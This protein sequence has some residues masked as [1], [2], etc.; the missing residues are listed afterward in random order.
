MHNVSGK[1]QKVVKCKI[2]DS[3]ATSPFSNHLHLPYYHCNNC[4]TVF[5][6]EIVDNSEEFLG[7][8]QKYYFRYE[9]VREIMFGEEIL[10]LRTFCPSGNFLDFGGGAGYLALKAQDNGYNAFLVEPNSVGREIA[11][12]NGL[13]Q[14][15][16][17][18]DNI[19]D[20]IEFDIVVINHAIE[21]FV[22]PIFELTRLFK[23]IK[24]GGFL[25]TTQPNLNFYNTLWYHLLSPL[26]L[27]NIQILSQGHVFAWKFDSLRFA[28][29]K[30]G[31]NRIEEVRPITG[32]VLYE[33]LPIT[34]SRIIVKLSYSIGINPSF[35][36]LARADHTTHLYSQKGEDYDKK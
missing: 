7:E 3:M 16:D 5:N 26:N 4:E 10:R 28:L 24:G 14:V 32:R 23:I 29:S 22:D 18:I 31:F 35:A 17:N 30:V 8:N 19:S 21:H 27:L 11:K 20:D 2:C 15:F 6:P 33:R 36:L 1:K 34:L 25:L 12:K 13:Y 9:K